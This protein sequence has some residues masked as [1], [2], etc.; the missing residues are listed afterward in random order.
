M[1]LKARKSRSEPEHATKKAGLARIERPVTRQYNFTI[2]VDLHR[3][4]RKCSF[5]VDIEMKELL[6]RMITSFVKTQ[7]NK[8]AKD[9]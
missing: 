3:E 5:E 2:P 1:A 4:F 9:S 6:I 7:K 8:A